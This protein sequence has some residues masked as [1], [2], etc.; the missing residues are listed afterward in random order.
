MFEHL[1]NIRVVAARVEKSLTYGGLKS[2]GITDENLTCGY[3]SLPRV[4]PYRHVSIEAPGAVGKSNRLSQPV[5]RELFHKFQIGTP[6]TATI[7]KRF[8]DRKL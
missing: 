2:R 5:L 1:R 6:S 4:V 8:L 3:S 7:R